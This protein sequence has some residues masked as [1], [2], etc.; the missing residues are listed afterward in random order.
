MDI[1]EIVKLQE[2]FTKKAFSKFWE[3]KNEE[4]FYNRLLFLS[5]ALSGE[6][7]EFNNIVKKLYRSKFFKEENLDLKEK[8]NE[9]FI[10]IFIYLLNIA[11]LLEID[12]EKEFLRKLEINKNRFLK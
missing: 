7:G 8:L 6:V 4:D 11:I 9:E 2:D 5:V 12:I 10:D 3:I 1:K